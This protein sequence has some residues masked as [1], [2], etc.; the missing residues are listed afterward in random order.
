MY[1]PSISE[2]GKLRKGTKADFL[3]RIE[4]KDNIAEGSEVNTSAKII[5]GAAMVQMLKP[6]HTK[7]YGVYRTEFLKSVLITA[8]VR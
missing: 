1:S 6:I 7:T 8:N 4:E 3:A 5:D 2:Y